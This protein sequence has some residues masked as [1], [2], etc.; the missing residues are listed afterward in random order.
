MQ[1]EEAEVISVTEDLPSCTNPDVTIDVTTGK[2]SIDFDKGE[3][4]LIMLFVSVLTY[5]GVLVF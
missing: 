5:T 4:L 3:W 1:E 2:V